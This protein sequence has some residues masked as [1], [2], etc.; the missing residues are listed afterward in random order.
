MATDGSERGRYHRYK[1]ATN[2]VLTWLQEATQPKNTNITVRARSANV[3]EWSVSQI[4]TAAL[5]VV[6]AA[7]PVPCRIL[8]E[9]GTAVRL[10]HEYSLKMPPDDGHMHVLNTFRAI[11]A[12][13]TPLVS[14]KTPTSTTPF[15]LTTFSPP[16]DATDA[17]HTRLV[18][19]LEGAQFQ[20]VFFLLDLDDMNREVKLA[21]EMFQRGEMSLIAATAV[22]NACV[23]TVDELSK[24]LRIAHPHFEDLDHIMAFLVCEE[25]LIDLVVGNA[26]LTLSTAVEVVVLA[27]RAM[28]DEFRPAAEH[29]IA[30]ALQ[31]TI[32]AAACLIDRV[33]N[34]YE[35]PSRFGDLEWTATLDTSLVNLQQ[36]LH[37][38]IKVLPPGTRSAVPDGFFNRHWPERHGLASSPSDLLKTFLAH[39]LPVFLLHDAGDVMLPREPTTNPLFTLLRTYVKT[40]RVPV[41]LVFACQSLLW[42]LVYTQGTSD[43]HYANIVDDTRVTIA[44]V[45][46]QLTTCCEFADGRFV[47]AATAS[48]MA[49][50]L[51]WLV[52]LRVTT[53]PSKPF[54]QME[55][56]RAWFNPYM[57]GQLLL[58]ITTDIT[59][60]LGLTTIDDIGQARAMIHLYNAL[61]VLDKIPANKDLDTLVAMFERGK[62]LWLSGR[63]TSRGDIGCGRLLAR[64]YNAVKLTSRDRL[65]HRSAAQKKMQSRCD[66]LSQRRLP[67]EPAHVSKAYRYVTRTTT[68]DDGPLTKLPRALHIKGVIDRDHDCFQYLN[69]CMVGQLFRG[70]WKEMVTAFSVSDLLL[71]PLVPAQGVVDGPRRETDAN[72]RLPNVNLFFKLLLILCARDPDDHRVAKAAEAMM[73]VAER[74]HE[75]YIAPPVVTK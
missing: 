63:P 45:T 56:D 1:A 5:E 31:T 71:V 44:R 69:L 4:W 12:R 46:S 18:A 24:T 68:S 16:T 61:R 72:V 58:T 11:E 67:I 7:T 39:I 33:L 3:A 22:T 35:T 15:D 52:N 59:F 50:A 29:T 13:W 73:H 25:L 19:R 32:T 37:T 40:K 10:R 9:L 26:D 54:G 53:S 49:M 41:A 62:S 75:A 70:A 38:M 74:M 36:G 43:A 48:N 20:C 65:D 60:T 30:K 66:A 64:S 23:H 51:R 55:V 14:A 2:V 17:A 42:S 47:P 8:R 27:K 6:E 57:A 34:Q 21:W 28:I